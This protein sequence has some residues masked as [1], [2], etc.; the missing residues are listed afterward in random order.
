[1]SVE[2]RNIKKY[3]VLSIEDDELYA[4]FLEKL[5]TIYCNASF[6]HSPNPSSG[7]DWL[8]ENQDVDLILLDLELPQMDGLKVL[9]NI[10]IQLGMK[11]LKI[12]PCTT[13]A[14]KNLIASLAKHGISDYIV[15]TTPSKIVAEKINKV[16]A[17]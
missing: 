13:L 14:N 8:V 5:V 11:D 15:K 1:M 16:L 4:G 7:L 10:R 9:K 12:I 17:S 2:K 3:K 6:H